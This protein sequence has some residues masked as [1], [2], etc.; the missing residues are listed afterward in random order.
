MVL[1]RIIPHDH[2]NMRDLS[3]FVGKDVFLPGKR[4]INSYI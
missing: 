1:G 3:V 2:N 4:H